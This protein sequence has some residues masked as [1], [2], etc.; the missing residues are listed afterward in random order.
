MSFAEQLLS[1]I[2]ASLKSV[3]SD[4]INRQVEAAKSEVERKVHAQADA[5][6]L[7]ILAQYDVRMSQDQL[8]IKV[9]KGDIK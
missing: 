5:I 9:S 6:A 2:D 1:S 7:K 8:V 4:E 3:I